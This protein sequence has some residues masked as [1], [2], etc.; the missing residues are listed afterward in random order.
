MG[1][2]DSMIVFEMLVPPIIIYIVFVQ[3]SSPPEV[4]SYHHAQYFI[5]AEDKGT[6]MHGLKSRPALH[7]KRCGPGNTAM[8]PRYPQSN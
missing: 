8:Q 5:A 4:I 6:I 7:Q 2:S 3:A 1:S